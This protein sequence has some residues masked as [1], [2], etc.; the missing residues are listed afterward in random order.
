MK[1]TCFARPPFFLRRLVMMLLG[2]FVQGFGLSFLIMI[3]WGTDPWTGFVIGLTK[4]F[5]ISYGNCQ[6]ICAAVLFLVIIAFDMSKIGFGTI[7]NMVIV[8][9]VADFFSGLWTRVIGEAFFDQILWSG[10]LLLP[11]LAVFLAGASA[12]LSADLG[13]SPYDAVPFILSAHIK[14]IPFKFVRMG[15]DVSFLVLGF[16]LGGP[17]GVITILIAFFLGPAIAWFQKKLSVFFKEKEA[18]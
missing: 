11:A 12:Y 17:I 10:L 18:A 16:L 2:V 14:R 4:H 5:P 7:G 9:Y 13:G 15:W 8:G 3:D 6:L 1:L